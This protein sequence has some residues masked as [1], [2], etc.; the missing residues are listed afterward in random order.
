MTLLQEAFTS[1]VCVT[2]PE[3][4][5]NEPRI[6]GLPEVSRNGP[7]DLSY[8]VASLAGNGGVSHATGVAPFGVMELKVF[9]NSWRTYWKHCQCE[10]W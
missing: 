2:V 1:S 10:D 3:E 9:E 4:P 5:W 6:L 8:C 7:G